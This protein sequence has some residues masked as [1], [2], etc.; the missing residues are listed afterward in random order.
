MQ[1]GYNYRIK[2]VP[3]NWDIPYGVAMIIKEEGTH[4]TLPVKLIFQKLSLLRANS[5]CNLCIQGGDCPRFTRNFQ[6]LK[7]DRRISRQW[8]MEAEEIIVITRP[9]PSS[10][11]GGCLRFGDPSKKEDKKYFCPEQEDLIRWFGIL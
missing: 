6:G 10:T 11:V 9:D 5:R 7:G 2:K 8:E 4:T 1:A 3:S